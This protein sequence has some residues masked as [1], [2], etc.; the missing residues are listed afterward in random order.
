QAKLKWPNDGLVEGRKLGGTHIELRAE[1][2]GP[3]CVVIGIGLNV[4]LGVPL[5]QKIAETGV[6]ATDLITA[7]LVQPSRNDI[8]AA[9]VNSC[10]RGLSDFESNGL[11][12]VS[13]AWREAEAVR[14]WAV[15]VTAGG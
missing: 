4:A 15:G 9:L 12:V 6:T 1:S 3:A 2:A 8:V 7:G 5:L 14:W 13:E 11:R 10:V